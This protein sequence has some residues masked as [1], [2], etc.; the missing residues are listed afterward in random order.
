MSVLPRIRFVLVGT[1]HPGNIGA[2][3]RAMK[4]MGLTQLVLVS[5]EKPLDE[6]AYRRSAGA[7]E[8]LFEAPI[9][10]DLAQAVADC[11]FV[12]GCSARCRRIQP[13]L[14]APEDAAQ[15]VLA[16]ATTGEQVA[17]VFGRERSGLS[18]AEL[19]LCHA[20]VHIPS[21]P[22]FSSLNLAA[23]VQVLAWE[24][25]RAQLAQA[26]EETVPVPDSSLIATHQQVE[27]FFQQLADT[28]EQIDFHKGRAPDSALHKLRRLFLRAKL[29]EQEVRLLR[30]IL[31]D[32]QRML[33]LSSGASRLE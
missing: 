24:L 25:R 12:I 5:P 1:Q 30:G 32:T 26:Q 3:A 10:T 22:Q 2:S 14:L 18:N 27:G 33:T 29:S 16:H 6:A 31:T 8:L 17:L 28:L 20:S 4:T 11:H 9:F 21:D 7:E 15:Q 13:Q 19:Q 23:A